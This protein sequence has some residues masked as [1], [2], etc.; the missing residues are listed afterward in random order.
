MNEQTKTF[1]FELVSPEA[2]LMS[3][4]AWQVMVPAEEGYMGV[5]ANHAPVVA[6]IKP[7]V[8]EI[9]KAEGEAS[10]KIFIAGGLVDIS[11][12]NLTLLAEEAVR[13]DALDGATLEKEI[14][15]LNDEIAVANDDVTKARLTQKITLAEAKQAALAA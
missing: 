6:T 2:K 8:V 4:Q 7:G 14:S 10:E 13:V 9:W 12:S 15:D 5:R 1:N 3:E 11:A